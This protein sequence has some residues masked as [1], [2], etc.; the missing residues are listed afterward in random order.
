M[1]FFSGVLR[2][3]VCS[4]V[5]MASFDLNKFLNKPSL[6][7]LDSCKKDDLLMVASHFQIAVVKQSREAEIRS[8]VYNRLVLDVLGLPAKDGAAV[9][10]V[11]V[12]SASVGSENESEEELMPA[13]EVEA[14]VR[15]RLPPFEP[16]SPVSTGSKGDMRLKVRLARL[17]FEAQEKAQ[18]RQAEMDL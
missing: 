9:G 2:A 6:E 14:D 12:S 13:A 15:A 10:S 16:F 11:E 1:F 17:Q 7:Q 5:S 18:T 8:V 4:V 3:S